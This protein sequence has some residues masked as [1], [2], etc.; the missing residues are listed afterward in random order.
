MKSIENVIPKRTDGYA[1]KQVQCSQAYFVGAG[2]TNP[3]A[4]IG[5]DECHERGY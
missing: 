1:T 2:S 5:D 3:E 4:P